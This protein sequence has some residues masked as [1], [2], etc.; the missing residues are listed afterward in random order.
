MTMRYDY[1]YHLMWIIKCLDQQ[2]TTSQE[3]NHMTDLSDHDTNYCQY[4]NTRQSKVTEQPNAR[5]SQ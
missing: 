1:G 4:F 2:P 3:H 5:S